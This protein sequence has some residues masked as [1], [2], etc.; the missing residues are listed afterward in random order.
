ML[1][2]G[3]RRFR[4]PFGECLE[5]RRLLV[6]WFVEV[7]GDFG[8]RTIAESPLSG[9]V[10]V[11]GTLG[12]RVG[13]LV[14]QRES[15]G[16]VSSARETH[17]NLLDDP[18]PLGVRPPVVRDT[19]FRTDGTR[20]DV[21]ASPSES[22]LGLPGS[23]G[24]PTMWINGQPFGQG[25]TSGGSDGTLLGVSPDSLMSVGMDA[26]GLIVASDGAPDFLIERKIHRADVALATNGDL[27]VGRVKNN[28]VFWSRET[29]G[30][31][32]REQFQRRATDHYGTG[33]SVSRSGVTG[34]SFVRLEA[35]APKPQ[36]YAG[37]WNPDGTSLRELPFAEQVVSVVVVD[38]IAGINTLHE[39]FLYFVKEDRLIDIDE[40]LGDMGGLPHLEP[41]INFITEMSLSPD[42]SG[43]NVLAASTA[44]TAAEPIG[45]QWALHVDLDFEVFPATA[46]DLSDVIDGVAVGVQDDGDIVVVGHD[47]DRQ[48][49]AGRIVVLAPDLDSTS[50]IDVPR[51]SGQFSRVGDVSNNGQWFSVSNELLVS[52]RGSIDDPSRLEP[53]G[54]VGETGGTLIGAIDGDGTV[55]GASDGLKVAVRGRLGHPLRAIPG[56]PFGEIHGVTERGEIAG[57][58][59]VDTR[60]RGTLHAALFN[61]GREFLPREPDDY[62]TEVLDVSAD[63]SMMA[64]E[65]IVL[66]TGPDD[67]D[68]GM[69]AH[70]GYYRDID[71]IVTVDQSADDYQRVLLTN[72][73]GSYFQGTAT[74]V[75][76]LRHGWLGGSTPDGKAWV[77]NVH[78]M[79]H[80]ILAVDWLSENG[81]H[82]AEEPSGVRD[83]LVD[84]ET[85]HYILFG[86]KTVLVK[87]EFGDDQAPQVRKVL[88]NS[89]L[90]DPPDLPSE[91][92]PTRWESQ[93]SDLRNIVVSFDEP[94]TLTA[95]E[96]VL[97]NLGVNAPV[98]SDEVLPLR[99]E[100][101]TFVGNDLVIDL[102][103]IDV[104]DGVYQLDLLATIADESGNPL[105]EQFV[106][107]GNAVNRFYQLTGDL[108]GDEGVSVF[109]FPAFAYWFGRPV[110]EA[111]EYMDVNKD[112]GISVFDF[113][114]LAD[115]F[116]RV[117]VFPTSLLNDTE[118]GAGPM[119]RNSPT[120]LSCQPRCADD[121]RSLAMRSD[122]L[123]DRLID[124]D[125]L[126]V[127]AAY[128]HKMG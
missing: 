97:T 123:D 121:P 38:G 17:A 109:D 60:G 99:D 104:S 94:V 11:S 27:I 112:G 29:G 68:F 73:D 4:R 118:S 36:F 87:I 52:E 66:A 69:E 127:L 43:L 64:T 96:L 93:R 95:K 10:H 5:Q 74:A 39:A 100:Q 119:R 46:I 113:P 82:L 83:W 98:D 84:Q 81:I 15:D 86:G 102:S 7:P 19:I 49:S 91:A 70:V 25:I 101:L 79:S 77:Y 41:D 65:R 50:I 23:V 78:S 75:T 33:Y 56:E 125:L 72:S 111:P 45:P 89:G 44:N 85:D 126:T 108:N 24:E 63:G 13:T 59:S 14:L 114:I 106:F 26:G 3:T 28:A 32:R 34:G 115:G 47:G 35:D 12:Q 2:R 105:S 18:L 58:V 55:F 37:F 116:G 103:S 71:G 51:T 31:W 110:P 107:R 120:S 117:V 122:L 9:E 54:H 80:P 30:D 61:S 53:I 1:R 22:S 21:G 128:T 6:S 90:Q 42:S 48:Q 76:D 124:E 67:A 8:A 92:A 57:G 88:V 40:F 16:T 62:V 20:I